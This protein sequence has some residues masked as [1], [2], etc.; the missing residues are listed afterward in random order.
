MR[1]FISGF[2]LCL[3]AMTVGVVAAQ[4]TD[5]G[6]MLTLKPGATQAMQRDGVFADAAW[7]AIDASS[8]TPAYSGLLTQF[9]RYAFQCT[10]DAYFRRTTAASG[11]DAASTDGVLAARSIIPITTDGTAFYVS[12]LNVSDATAN[13]QYVKYQ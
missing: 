3:V 11:Q 10:A 1:N 8:A 7:T 9:S 6:D 4:N 12:V 2:V 13:C 5:G